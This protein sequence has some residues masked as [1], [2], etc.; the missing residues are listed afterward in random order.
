MFSPLVRRSSHQ[1]PF[2]LEPGRQS[3]GAL[4]PSMNEFQ[5]AWPFEQLVGDG[6]DELLDR[7]CGWFADASSGHLEHPRRMPERDV[8]DIWRKR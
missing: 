8:P 5:V 6:V 7:W 2:A 4:G 1:S 3:A